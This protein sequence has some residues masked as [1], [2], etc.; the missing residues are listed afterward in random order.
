MELAEIALMCSTYAKPKQSQ[1]EKSEIP[2]TQEDA[3]AEA[4]YEKLS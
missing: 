4:A 2:K 1:P 3:I